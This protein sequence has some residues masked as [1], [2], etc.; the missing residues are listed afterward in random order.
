MV[1]ERRHLPDFAFT[2]EANSN[3][4]DKIDYTRAQCDLRDG[5]PTRRK[6]HSIQ[7]AVT[8]VGAFFGVLRYPVAFFLS[9]DQTTSSNSR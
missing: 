9:T 8:G 6:E 5:V 1:I 2:A 7:F 4:N 3:Q